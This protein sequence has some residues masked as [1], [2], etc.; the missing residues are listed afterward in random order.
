MSAVG[1]ITSSTQ[2]LQLATNLRRVLA[3]SNAAPARDADGDND[4]SPPGDN[5]IW[6]PGKGG[7]ID[8][9]A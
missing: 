2:A 4:R 8:T 1:S 9:Y 6:A 3:S 5:G 7:V